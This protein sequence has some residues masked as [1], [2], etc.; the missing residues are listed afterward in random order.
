MLLGSVTKQVILDA[1]CDV[2]VVSEGS[3]KAV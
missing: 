1:S 3:L 2:L